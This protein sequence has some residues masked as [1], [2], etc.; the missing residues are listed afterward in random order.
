VPEGVD[1]RLATD[2]ID[3]VADHRV[4]WPGGALADHAEGDLSGRAQLVPD[5]REGLLEVVHRALRR[6]ETPHGVAAFFDHATDQRE[7]ARQAPALRRLSGMRST[8]VGCID[9]LRNPAAA[10]R[11]APGRCVSL[12]QP[13]RTGR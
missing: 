2:S 1:E 5:A 13:L 3:L 12:G 9:A 11:A 7:H 8:A 10:C 4:H 6:A